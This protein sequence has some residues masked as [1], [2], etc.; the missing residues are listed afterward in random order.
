MILKSFSG[1]DA[2]ISELET[3]HAQ[4]PTAAKV[5]IKMNRGEIGRTTG[6]EKTVHLSE[7]LRICYVIFHMHRYPW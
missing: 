7:V 2:D 3:L 6:R 4:A 5:Q 1:E